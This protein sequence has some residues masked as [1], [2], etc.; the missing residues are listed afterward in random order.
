MMG[1]SLLPFVA[2]AVPI[3]AMLLRFPRASA[4]S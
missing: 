3:G 4:A 2:A 1:E